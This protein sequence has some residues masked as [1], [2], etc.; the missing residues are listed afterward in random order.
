MSTSNPNFTTVSAPA[1]SEITGPSL[2]KTV[3]MLNNMADQLEALSDSLHKMWKV[4]IEFDSK[5]ALE[6]S[7]ARSKLERN[8]RRI[9]KQALYIIDHPETFGGNHD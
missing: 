7:E 2:L 9:R 5:L 4:A 1:H 8:A 3:I 6:I